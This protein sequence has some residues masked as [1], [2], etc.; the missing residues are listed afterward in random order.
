MRCNQ[1]SV[2]TDTQLPVM[3]IGAAAR[4]L[5]AAPCGPRCANAGTA[6][7]RTDASSEPAR[8]AAPRPL[9]EDRFKAVAGRI[10]VLMRF[11]ARNRP[12]LFPGEI[13]VGGFDEH[14]GRP[15]AR[16]RPVEA[17][18]LERWPGR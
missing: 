5:A 4:A 17:V 11:P 16:R 9:V 15:G 1:S 18:V 3:S 14:C 8:T 13:R 7:I 2:T 6:R 10:P 12:L